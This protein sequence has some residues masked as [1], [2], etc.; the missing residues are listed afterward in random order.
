[1]FVLSDIKQEKQSVY[2][3]VFSRVTVFKRRVWLFERRVSIKKL[4][5]IFLYTHT[6]NNPISHYRNDEP[7]GDGEGRTRL[8]NGQPDDCTEREVPRFTL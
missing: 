1:M 6:R 4:D 5:R 2:I 8:P 3:S 7:R